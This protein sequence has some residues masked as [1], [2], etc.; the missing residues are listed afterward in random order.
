MLQQTLQF[1]KEVFD[2]SFTIATS[3]QEN[4]ENILKDTLKL[5]PLIPKEGKELCLYYS[6][7]YWLSLNRMRKTSLA[8][9]DLFEKFTAPPSGSTE[10]KTEIRKKAAPA[11][12]KKITAKP[13]ASA[14]NNTAVKKQAK[15]APAAAAKTAEKS[16]SA[17]KVEQA[18]VEKPGPGNRTKKTQAPGNTTAAGKS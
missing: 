17:T 13:K 18:P 12:P 1:Q 4:C 7:Q 15:D 2:A 3:V 9:I 16:E 14:K 5:Y 10:K 11:Q 6:E 8:S